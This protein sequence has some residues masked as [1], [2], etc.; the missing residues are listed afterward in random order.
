MIMVVL[1][2]T[3]YDRTAGVPQVF[4]II[5]GSDFSLNVLTVSEMLKN[6]LDGRM[7][8]RIGGSLLQGMGR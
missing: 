5:V 3:I 6:F 7:M 8:K 2:N 1:G 4:H